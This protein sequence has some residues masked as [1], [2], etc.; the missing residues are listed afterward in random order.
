[1]EISYRLRD[2]AGETRVFT[3]TL[4][5][6]SLDL[7]ATPAEPLP[8]W[9]ALGFHQCPNCP[10]NRQTHSHCP[11]AAQL[12]DLVEYGAQLSSHEVL[13]AEVTTAQRTTAKEATAQQALSS[14]MGLIT[15]T[16]GCPNTRFLRPMARFHLPFADNL[17]TVYRVVSMYLLGQY[18][19]HQDGVEMDMDLQQLE[20]HYKNIHTVN[21]YVAKRLRSVSK[22]DSA[23]NALTKLDTYSLLLPRKIRTQL[24]DI[25]HLFDA[26]ANN[27]PQD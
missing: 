20:E 11:L 10:L 16:S 9:T 6:T 24:A 23:L 12:V 3:L 2:S 18:F 21:L 8:Q 5:P 14:L 7:V 22:Q 13:H 15:A 17:E 19:S 4:H 27:S 25:A 1:M 26:S